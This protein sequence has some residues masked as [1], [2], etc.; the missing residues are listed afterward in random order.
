MR[1]IAMAKFLGGIC[2]LSLV[3]MGCVSSEANSTV[4]SGDWVQ[5]GI[6]AGRCVLRRTIAANNESKRYCALGTNAWMSV[7]YYPDGLVCRIAKGPGADGPIGNPV[8]DEREFDFWGRELQPAVIPREIKGNGSYVHCLSR[9]YSGAS[10]LTKDYCFDMYYFVEA[11]RVIK[12]CT[13]VLDRKCGRMD[14]I[15]FTVNISENG[16]ASVSDVEE[17][18][19]GLGTVRNVLVEDD[20]S[21]VVEFVV[22]MVCEEVMIGRIIPHVGIQK[23]K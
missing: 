12:A 7:E 18:A 1:V 16:E 20:G 15:P 22:K 8:E 5:N 23:C 21:I 2:T 3:A 6:G 19:D 9:V 4:G 17:R 10:V 11:D 14:K 13:W